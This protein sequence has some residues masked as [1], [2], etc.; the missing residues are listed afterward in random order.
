MPH[1]ICAPSKRILADTKKSFLF[2]QLPLQHGHYLPIAVND[3]KP[4]ILLQP[5][6]M[7]QQHFS[8]GRSQLCSLLHYRLFHHSL[9]QSINIQTTNGANTCSNI[10]IAHPG[11]YFLA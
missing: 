5:S 9:V 1:G 6:S 2:T 10:N 8:I 7:D 11:W 3:S 4:F